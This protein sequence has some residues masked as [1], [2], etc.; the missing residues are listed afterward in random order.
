MPL[1]ALAGS[2]RAKL[3][4]STILVQLLMLVLLTASAL[5]I[6]H[7]HLLNQ[8]R[9]RIQE[10]NVLL[11]AALSG[12]MAQLDHAVVAE[13]LVATHS[14]QGLYYLQAYD[15]R[16]NLVAA[17]GPRTLHFPS[18]GDADPGRD[19]NDG[20]YDA[21][22]PI[23]LSG[24][25]L[26]QLRY[27]L[28]T[29]FLS[30]ARSSALSQ[31]L[32]ISGL[33]L[34]LSIVVLTGLG[35]WLTRQ[36]RRLT[37][38]AE[39]VSSG[40][41]DVRLPES[42]ND[43]VGRLVLAFNRMIQCLHDR[44][45]E[46]RISQSH[47]IFMAERDSLTGL[48]NR[49]FFRQELQRRL[50]ESLREGHQGALL[51]FDL[52]EFK[53]V[54]DTYGHQAGDELLVRVANEVGRLVRRNEIFCRLG[55]DEFVLILPLATEA[56]AVALASRIVAA[57]SAMRFQVQDQL[58][59]L[60]GSL[61]IALY[62]LHAADPD[63]LMAHAD[64]AMYRAKQAGKNTW[65]MF[66]PE[67]DS[68]P[69]LAATLAWKERIAH[70]LEHDGLVLELQGVYELPHG[71][72][73]HMEALVRMRDGVSGKLIS[74]GQFIPVAE[75]NRQILDIDRWVIRESVRRLG[76]NPGMP[77]VAVNVSGRSFDEPGLPD[78][79][80]AQLAEHAVIPERLI[81]EVTE[82]AAVADLDDAERFIQRLRQIGCH[83]CLDDFG[84]GFASFAYLKHMQVD[85]I[86]I[87]GLFI[88]NL[89][90]DEQNQVFVRAMVQVARGLG[91]K[92]VAECVEDGETLG[93]LVGFGVDLVQGYYLG[94]PQTGLPAQHTAVELGASIRVA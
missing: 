31:S 16:G 22:L 32:L 70:A 26:G 56:Q 13:I 61:G 47:L 9:I 17:A 83:I 15:T 54:N 65:R 10:L 72:L 1:Q 62:P 66:Q 89:P 57:L 92:T 12:P 23:T 78:Y 91:V 24:Q 19:G 55:G 30:M 77:A 46:L 44:D 86:K 41:Y 68:T 34:I 71:R 58:L 63:G 73:A 94:R 74:P 39:T 4:A 51:L 75:K 18:R 5:N 7:E 48:Y 37:D 27:G 84:A 88:R 93:M 43:E 50:D 20:V 45:Q 40:R 76:A 25:S 79:I 69:T 36:L 80:A 85:T 6:L 29:G 28:S 49:H 8:A 52:D 2:L 81:I 67:A 21:L 60:S 59:R 35:I 87:D 33:A 90:S 38:A 14:E 3:I 53:L 42:G 11:N 64:T 82:T